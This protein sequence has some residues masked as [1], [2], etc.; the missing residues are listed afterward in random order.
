MPVTI[1]YLRHVV[2]S[3]YAIPSSFPARG[4]WKHHLECGHYELRKG[5]QDAPMRCVCR[6]CRLERGG[7]R[8]RKGGS[9]ELDDGIGGGATPGRR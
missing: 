4:Y 9:Y 5:S 1:N 6:D 8:T 7:F 2:R 3:E